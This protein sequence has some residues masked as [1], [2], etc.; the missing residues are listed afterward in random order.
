MA[1]YIAARSI[2][3]EHKK[4]NGEI[5]GQR[6]SKTAES[7]ISRQDAAEIA[8]RVCRSV[9]VAHVLAAHSK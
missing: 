2:M 8:E 1:I 5:C 6:F 4:P 7:N 9:Y 3:C